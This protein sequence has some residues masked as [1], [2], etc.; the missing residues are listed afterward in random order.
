MSEDIPEQAA[1]WHARQDRDDMDWLGF[2]AWLEVD[3][4]HRDAFD[5]VA[6]LDERIDRQRHLLVAA[7]ALPAARVGRRPAGR[8][9]VPWAAGGVAA[10]AAVAVGVA[11]LRQPDPATTP[12]EYRAGAAVRVIDLG[13]ARVLLAPGSVLAAEGGDARLLSLSGRAAFDVRHDPERPLLVRAGSYRIT[14][15]GTRFEIVAGG[16]TIN[17]AVVEGRVSVRSPSGAEV[18]VGAGRSLT[19]FA[20]GRVASAGATAANMGAWGTGPLSYDGVPLGVVAADV[21]RVSGRVVKAD[22]SVESRPFTGVVAPAKG[23]AMAASLASLAG[24]QS[25]REGD[26]IR[27]VDPAS[28]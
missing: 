13:G 18:E 25:R 22:P 7:R 4:R 8:R 14:D 24:L 2:T 10:V 3:P 19:G 16:G 20:D 17:V 11:T 23:E 1:L 15:V 12:T 9:S 6:L 21:S 26:A 28:R 27:L 5:Q